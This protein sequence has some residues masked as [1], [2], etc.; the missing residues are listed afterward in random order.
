MTK[1]EYTPTESNTRSHKWNLKKAN[2][3][4][5]RNDSKEMFNYE[6]TESLEDSHTNFMRDINTICN[7]NIPRSKDNHSKPHNTVPWWTEECDLAIRKRE[8]ARKNYKHSKSDDDFQTFRRART[9]AKNV[10]KQVRKK[11]WQDYIS[12]IDSKTNSKEIWDKV[13]RFRGKQIKPV[14]VLITADQT[15]Q[16]D[17]QNIS[18]R[19]PKH[20]GNGA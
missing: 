7:N 15:H 11:K 19:S 13:N 16:T 18:S 2:W 1:T 6:Q 9:E 5:F 14:S 10:L 8:N 4:K 12:Q 20:R 3:T 17:K